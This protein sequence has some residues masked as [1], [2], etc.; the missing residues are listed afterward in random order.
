MYWCLCTIF[1]LGRSIIILIFFLLGSIFFKK[2]QTRYN[3]FWFTFS[4]YQI[5]PLL[6]VLRGNPVK[7]NTPCITNVYNSQGGCLKLKS[8]LLCV[9]VKVLRKRK[10]RVSSVLEERTHLP[11]SLHLINSR[12][13]P[14]YFTSSNVL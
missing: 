12:C 10:L 7:L 6:Q 11:A 14:L 2:P 4:S 8:H 5:T 1:T 3:Y 13:F 9:V